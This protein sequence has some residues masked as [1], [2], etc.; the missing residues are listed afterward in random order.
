VIVH[1]ANEARQR[2]CDYVLFTRFEKK[3][4][5]SNSLI[6]KAVGLASALGSADLPGRS[7]RPENV[8]KTATSGAT[9]G[10]EVNNWYKVGDRAALSY[11]LYPSGAVKPLHKGKFEENIEK[12][13]E[14]VVTALLLKAANQLLPKI[15]K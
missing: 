2:E 3:K 12:E 9:V 10:S 4:S 13:G 1:A 5:S 14:T 11:E 8:K 7:S 15:V 6:G